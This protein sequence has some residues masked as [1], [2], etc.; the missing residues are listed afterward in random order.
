MAFT[1]YTSNGCSEGIIQH[2]F[3]EGI[4]GSNI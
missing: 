4:L 3:K 1:S 2:V